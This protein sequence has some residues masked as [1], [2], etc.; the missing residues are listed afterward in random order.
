MKLKKFLIFFVLVFFLFSINIYSSSIFDVE[1]ITHLPDDVEGK[2][3]IVGYSNYGEII[4]MCVYLSNREVKSLHI[5]EDGIYDQSGELLSMSF[6]KYDSNT[7]EWTYYTLHT[8]NTSWF[9][10]QGLIPYY[11]NRDLYYNDEIYIFG[12]EHHN[13]SGVLSGLS[14]SVLFVSLLKPLLDLMPFILAFIVLVLTFLKM[15]NFI[16]EVF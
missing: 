11:S 16:K 10:E 4:F 1:N 5:R 7:G 14:S 15:W 12:K 8:N 3:Y 6:R 9:T 2:P 13:N